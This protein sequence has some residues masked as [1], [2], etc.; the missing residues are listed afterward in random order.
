MKLFRKL[1]EI[2]PDK[3]IIGILLLFIPITVVL[4]SINTRKSICTIN[5]IDTHFKTWVEAN[6]SRTESNS[7]I[8]EDGDLYTETETDTW[9][10]Q[11]STTEYVETRNGIVTNISGNAV[12]S[13]SIKCVSPDVDPTYTK[14]V[15]FDNFSVQE[16]LTVEVMLNTGDKFTTSNDK[17][18]FYFKDNNF[19]PTIEVLVTRVFGTIVRVEPNK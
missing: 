16:E 5:Y 9:E 14:D 19:D 8:D 12:L 3:M 11:C 4:F 10:E 15:D 2:S 18:F 7:G 1:K 17:I 6:Y 13:N